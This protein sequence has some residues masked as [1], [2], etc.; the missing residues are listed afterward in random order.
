METETVS[1]TPSILG[2]AKVVVSRL[3]T[4]YDSRESTNIVRALVEEVI[5]QPYKWL[6]LHPEAVFTPEQSTH[7]ET[8]VHRILQG[9]PLQYVI[10]KAWFYGLE[11]HV[12]PGVLIPRPETEELVEAVLQRLHRSA[13][14]S[15]VD[16]GTGSGCIPLAL[17]KNLPGAQVTGVDVSE[18]ALAI[19]K[20]NAERLG[21][22]CEFRLLDVLAASGDEFHSLD[23]LVSNPPYI[24][25][26]E[27]AALDAHVRDHEPALALKVPDASPLLFYIKV[28]QLG[29]TWLR[30]GGWLLFEIHENFGQET[31]NMMR[32]TGYQDVE[33]LPDL[34]GRDRIAVGKKF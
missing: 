18:T 28:S 11:L 12:A 2:T 24:P 16:I 10:G 23:I 13:G 7:F 19:A 6:L 21:I 30:P 14:I 8:L 22:Q 29:L 25:E 3:T 20:A 27:W 4:K 9:E 15:I 32:F 17:A 33:I 31:A 26:S 34:Q 1:G 5:R